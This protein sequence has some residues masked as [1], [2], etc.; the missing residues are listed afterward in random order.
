M[1]NKIMIIGAACIVLS[2]AG[3]WIKNTNSTDKIVAKVQSGEYILECHMIDDGV[4]VIDKYKVI[5]FDGEMWRFKENGYSKNC[6]VKV[7]K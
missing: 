7:A 1:K 6:T 4:K 2:T 3:A 5:G